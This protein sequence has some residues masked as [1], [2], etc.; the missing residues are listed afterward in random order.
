MT[1]SI[2]ARIAKT[3]SGVVRTIILAVV[4]CGTVG[5]VLGEG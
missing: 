1:R 5:K 2:L 4:L 3:C